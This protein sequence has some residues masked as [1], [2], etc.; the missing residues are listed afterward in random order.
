LFWLPYEIVIDV[1]EVIVGILF[2]VGIGIIAGV[3]GVT[4]FTIYFELFGLFNY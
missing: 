3:I 1:A 2:V 4:L